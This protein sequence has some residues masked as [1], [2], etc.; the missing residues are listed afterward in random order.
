MP[1][2]TQG[3]S[4][5][6]N[7]WTW[8][9]RCNTTFQH[10]KL[11]DYRLMG[12]T[13]LRSPHIENLQFQLHKRMPLPVTNHRFE[14][15][16]VAHH[17]L[18]CPLWTSQKSCS[19]SGQ[20]GNAIH[21]RTSWYSVSCQKPVATSMSCPRQQWRSGRRPK[22]W[23]QK[24]ET[25]NFTQNPMK[26]LPN[27]KL[28]S[29]NKPSLVRLV[30]EALRQAK[31][32]GLLCCCCAVGSAPRNQPPCGTAVHRR[33]P[34][35]RTPLT[36]TDVW[37]FLHLQKNRRFEFQWLKISKRKQDANFISWC[38]V[39]AAP[40]WHLIFRTDTVWKHFSNKLD[41]RSQFKSDFRRSASG[42]ESHSSE[43]IVEIAEVAEMIN[44]W[45]LR[46][47]EPHSHIEQV[48]RY[49]AISTHGPTFH[50]QRD[51]RN[52]DLQNTTCKFS[53]TA[54]IGPKYHGN[55]KTSCFPGN[56]F[57]DF[58]TLNVENHFTTTYSTCWKLFICPFSMIY[59][60]M[61]ICLSI[62]TYAFLDF[63]SFFDLFSL[64]H[65]YLMY[66]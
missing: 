34:L 32:L 48:R 23:K 8:N 54:E 36:S 53:R 7:L 2:N 3:L 20:Y 37:K 61:F 58:L 33:R 16:I 56:L 43:S 30:P 11:N 51:Q 59:F 62:Y 14:S 65:S 12:S 13:A 52:V 25:S 35:Q 50:M 63:I 15:T 40:D 6:W 22:S 47:S 27:S 9:V 10:Q 31:L 57:E 21:H 19:S 4:K 45:S 55:W 46:F 24:V 66:S 1:R 42:A 29:P 28:E 41:A 39:Q 17:Y 5:I 38:R 64:V 44:G 26:M 18:W 49:F 60:D